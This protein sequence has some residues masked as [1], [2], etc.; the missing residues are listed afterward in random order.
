MG[1][2]MRKLDHKDTDHPVHLLSLSSA[3]SAFVKSIIIANLV[4]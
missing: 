2:V 4:P 3:A 1:L